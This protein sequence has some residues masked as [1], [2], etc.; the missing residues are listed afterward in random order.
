MD[1]LTGE[2]VRVRFYRANE[3][4]ERTS[5]PA[6][7][8]RIA[9]TRSLQDDPLS[10]GVSGY[11]ARQ[12]WGFGRVISAWA[13]NAD[14]RIPVSHWFSLTGE[15]YHGRAIGGLGAAEGQSVAFT[16]PPSAPQ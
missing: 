15:F 10:I 4:G 2:L 14:C 1:P 3:A 12:N 5:Q 16:G 7:A 8:G 11:Y 9:W 6:Y 13:G